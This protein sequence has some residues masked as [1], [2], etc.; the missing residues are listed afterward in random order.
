MGVHGTRAGRGREFTVAVRS[1]FLSTDAALN[2]RLVRAGVGLTMAPEDRVRDEVARRV[3]ALRRRTNA[4]FRLARSIPG[5]PNV[6]DG[7]ASLTDA[8]A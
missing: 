5:M 2:L 6:L 4:V 7:S 3:R 8:A 1:R